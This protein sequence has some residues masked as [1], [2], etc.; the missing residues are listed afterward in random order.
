VRSPAEAI[1]DGPDAYHRRSVAPTVSGA[2]T[3]LSS[4][5]VDV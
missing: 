2:D 1:L 5:V 4:H 3:R